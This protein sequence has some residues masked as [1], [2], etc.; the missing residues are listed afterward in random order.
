M[1]SV[2]PSSVGTSR[3]S[4]QRQRLTASSRRPARAESRSSSTQRRGEAGTVAR[5]AGSRVRAG[6]PAS[7]PRASR[8]TVRAAPRAP[9]G[10]RRDRGGARRAGRGEAERVEEPVGLGVVPRRRSSGRPPPPSRV[11]VQGALSCCALDIRSTSAPRRR[12]RARAS[13][14]AS[15]PTRRAR[16]RASRRPARS[17]A[18]WSWPA[19]RASPS[20]R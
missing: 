13:G 16:C 4:P 20:P 7:P 19:S 8:E 15:P 14:R 17:R 10:G 3:A 1:T 9:G 11:E 12:R 2:T 5:R 18:A 6:R